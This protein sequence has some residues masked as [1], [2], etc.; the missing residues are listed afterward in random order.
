MA[1]IREQCSWVHQDKERATE[2]AKALVTAAVKRVYYHEPLE[3]KEVT[4]NPC[5]L[6]VGAGIAGIQ[7]AL[8]IA[9]SGHKVYLLERE[10]SIGGNMARLDKTFPTLDCSA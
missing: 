7:A 8:E 9:D 5:T 1:N 2:K 4:V 6:V 10:P 3:T